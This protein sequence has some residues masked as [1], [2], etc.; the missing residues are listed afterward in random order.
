MIAYLLTV[1]SIAQ[2][3]VSNHEATTDVRASS[4]ETRLRR[5]S[6]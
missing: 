4:F 3:C 5:S 1:R 6:G 2:Q